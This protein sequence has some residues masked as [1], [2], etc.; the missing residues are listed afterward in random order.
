M[1]N[2]PTNLRTDPSNRDSNKG[3]VSN[4]YEPWTQLVEAMTAINLQ[5]YPLREFLGGRPDTP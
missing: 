1:D 3:F 4:T 5:V 2:D